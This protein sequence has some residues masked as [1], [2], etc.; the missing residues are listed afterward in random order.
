MQMQNR[1][2]QPLRMVLGFV[3]GF[4]FFFSACARNFF[5]F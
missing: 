2:Q 4:V 1:V 5:I 3:G